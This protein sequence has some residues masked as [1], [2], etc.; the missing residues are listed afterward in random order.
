[1]LSERERARVVQLMTYGDDADDTLDSDLSE[2]SE[3]TDGMA[4]S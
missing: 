3:P 1:M 4:S 2:A